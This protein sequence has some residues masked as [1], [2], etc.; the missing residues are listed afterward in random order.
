M[1]QFTEDS[2]FDAEKA[3]R[4]I[5]HA[6]AVSRWLSA[7]ATDAGIEILDPLHI[8]VSDLII[9]CAARG[10]NPSHLMRR[11]EDEVSIAASKEA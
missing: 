8:S 1:T 11:A 6:D 9:D 10:I 2:P 7:L 3:T 4:M 5:N